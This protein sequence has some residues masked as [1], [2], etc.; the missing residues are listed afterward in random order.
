M[1][2]SEK[3]RLQM[4]LQYN[5]TTIYTQKQREDFELSTNKNLILPKIRFVFKKLAHCD[6]LN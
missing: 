1:Q 3:L 4:N 6:C 2:T 5:G